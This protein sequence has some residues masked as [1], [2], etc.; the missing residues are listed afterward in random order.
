MRM[1]SKHGQ[2]SQRNIGLMWV[3]LAMLIWPVLV[4]F[5]ASLLFAQGGIGISIAQ[6]IGMFAYLFG[7]L[8]MFIGLI[9]LAVYF[10]LRFVTKIEKNG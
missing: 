8:S 6:A 7:A 3:G 9:L 1:E 2:I 10:Y 5:L 4:L